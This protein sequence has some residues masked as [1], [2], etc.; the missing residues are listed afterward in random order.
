MKTP[1]RRISNIISD[2]S[3]QTGV[4]KALSREI[5]AYLLRERR[6]A[7]LDSVMRDVQSNWAAAGQVE[8]IAASAHPLTAGV[9]ADITKQAKAIYPNAK[10]IIVTEVTDPTVLGGVRLNLANQQLD[11]S[12]AAKLNK[13]KQLT[14]VGK[15]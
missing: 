12:V 7:E 5:A 14:A 9:K 8:V 15:E 11:L 10:K 13:F 4:S 1:R 6:V 2:R 3:L